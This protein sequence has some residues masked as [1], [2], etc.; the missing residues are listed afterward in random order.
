MIVS[1]V[2]EIKIDVKTA[3][4]LLSLILEQRPAKNLRE[5]AMVN[6][7][8][9]MVDDAEE[10]DYSDAESRSMASLD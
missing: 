9:R 7:F 10:G 3:R 1:L 8:R 6:D 2:K 5:A 4:G